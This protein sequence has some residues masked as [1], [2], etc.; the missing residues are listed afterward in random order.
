ML[1]SYEIVPF[2][3]I[4]GIDDLHCLD[5]VFLTYTNTIIVFII[6]DMVHL[7]QAHETLTILCYPVSA[8]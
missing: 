2:V 3:D 7:A 1:R 5:F 8:L 6:K 4:G